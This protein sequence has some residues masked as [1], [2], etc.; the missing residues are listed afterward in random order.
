MKYRF[1]PL[2]TLL[3]FEACARHGSFRKAADELCITPPAV[4]HQIKQLEAWL[5]TSLFLR[6][7]RGIRLTEPGRQLFR[8]LE[9][10][11][12]TLNQ[13]LH[14]FK[15]EQS[16]QLTLSLTPA[17]STKWLVTR[18]GRFWHEHPDIELKLHHSLATV[19]LRGG[20]ADMAIRWGEGDWPE[21]VAEPLLSGDLKPVCSPDL[22]VGRTLTGPADLEEYVLLHED[23]R[24]DWQRWLALHGVTLANADRG[25]I[26]D[27]AASLLLAAAAGQGVALGRVAV[28]TEALTA[29]RLVCP[30][31]VALP[32][33]KGYWLVYPPALKEQDAAMRLREFLLKEAGSHL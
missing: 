26:I 5:E 6:L 3:T 16:S 30:F 13:T 25:P 2:P 29:G 15:V 31:D 8:E 14:E 21:L 28:L 33:S 27:D 20:E 12:T 4:T 17:L 9:Q 10:Q 19:N 32:S 1:P 11:L 22:L 18:L 24:D 7:S 23:S